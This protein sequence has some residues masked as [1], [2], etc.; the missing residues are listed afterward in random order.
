MQA[1]PLTE[2]PLKTDNLTKESPYLEYQIDLG[3]SDSFVEPEILV[4]AIPTLPITNKHGVRVGVQW[5]KE[6][7]QIV[8]FTTFGRSEEWKQNVLSNSATKKAA[9]KS[10]IKG[11]NSLRIYLIDEG[12]ALDYFYI[13]LNKNIPTPYS[14][15]PETTGRK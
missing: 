15:L 1:Y 11:T 3:N 4:H 5:N 7:I 2:N 13:L 14:I 9:I 6:P 10:T 12:V 8:D